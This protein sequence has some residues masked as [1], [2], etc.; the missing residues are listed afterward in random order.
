MQISGSAISEQNSTEYIFSMSHMI[1]CQ[2]HS[3]CIFTSLKDV[4]HA[5]R[6]LEASDLQHALRIVQIIP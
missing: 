3:L 2:P 1:Y 5:I 6:L 4:N